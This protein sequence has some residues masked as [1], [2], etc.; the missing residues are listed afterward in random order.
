M[1][2]SLG[3]THYSVSKGQANCYL[4]NTC[5]HSLRIIKNI[6]RNSEFQFETINNE[7][8]PTLGIK[9]MAGQIGTNEQLENSRLWHK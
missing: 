7:I 9:A 6:H 1:N 5:T 4:Q 2:I 8:K 3:S